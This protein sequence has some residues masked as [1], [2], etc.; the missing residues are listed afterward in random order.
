M[1]ITMKARVSFTMTIVVP[2]ETM[3]HIAKARQAVRDVDPATFAS[4]IK[5]ADKE[6]RYRVELFRG[7]KT[8][9]QVVQQIYRSA[10]RQFIRNDFRKEICSNESQARIGDTIVTFE[11]VP[12]V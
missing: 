1:S 9:E 4:K 11:E 2:T 5:E 12:R 8:D 10:M 6:E 3:E 7:D